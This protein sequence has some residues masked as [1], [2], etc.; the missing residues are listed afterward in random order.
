[1]GFTQLAVRVA[2]PRTP[3]RAADITM[4]GDSGALYSVVPAAVLHRLGIRP[5]RR[6]TFTLAD[7]T[8][9]RRQIGGAM[10]EVAGRR[11]LSSVMFGR[12]GDSVLLG[13]VTLEELGLMIDPLRQR[14]KPLHPR[15]GAMGPASV[16]RVTGLDAARARATAGCETSRGTLTG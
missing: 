11:G 10:F 7:G 14:L 1:M 4:L 3:G 5:E 15:L 8:T 13:V 12:A 2:N 16:P 9:V 6:E